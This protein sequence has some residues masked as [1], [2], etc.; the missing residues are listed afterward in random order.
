MFLHAYIDSHSNILIDE[1]LGDG[2]Q[3]ITRLQSKCANMTF[4]EKSDVLHYFRKYYTQ[5][6]S[7]KSIME[8][9]F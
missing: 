7:Q 1:Y 8:I 9:Y 2:L 6:G 4:A 5:K 3:A